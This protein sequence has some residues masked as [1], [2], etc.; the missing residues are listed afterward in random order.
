MTTVVWSP[1]CHEHY[2]G[3]GHPERPQRIAAVLD[4]L[5]AP[6]M[7]RHVSWVEARPA[8]RTVLERVH[9]PEIGR[10]SCRERV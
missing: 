4:A 9:P 3:A 10:A 2:A 8:E 6:D 1:V 5:R 7:A